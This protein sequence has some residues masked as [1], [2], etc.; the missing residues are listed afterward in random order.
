MGAANLL[1]ALVMEPLTWIDSREY[2]LL[3][4]KLTTVPSAPNLLLIGVKINTNDSVELL[5]WYELGDGIPSD[6]TP[7]DYFVEFISLN[8]E[9][10]E[11]VNFQP[12]EIKDGN[13]SFSESLFAVVYPEE[14]N[15]VIIKHKDKI[16][17]EV[18][19][20]KPPFIDIKLIREKDR[21][22]EVKWIVR[23]Q[24]SKD[25]YYSLGYS[26]NNGNWKPIIINTQ[27]TSHS[28]DG[29]N[30]P[31][32]STCILKLIA[33]DGLNT[34]RINKTFAS[35]ESQIECND[36]GIHLGNNKPDCHEDQ[37]KDKSEGKE[38]IR[39]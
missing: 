29:S 15:K 21:I 13:L 33:T 12:A 28:F 27:K 10:L 16:L 5:P 14:T 11:T 3:L 30:I 32:N 24:D 39:H 2:N 38:K 4:S 31:K 34:V 18:I 35:E 20:G 23:D 9:L 8:G 22:Y 25:L 1:N 6:I 37:G 19:K 36:N 26:C 17:K 7:G